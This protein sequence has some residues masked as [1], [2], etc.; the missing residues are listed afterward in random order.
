MNNVGGSFFDDPHRFPPPPLRVRGPPGRDY[1]YPKP[2][3]GVVGHAVQEY[4]V[5]VFPEQDGFPGHHCVLAARTLVSVMKKE[6]A[7]NSD[8]IG[9]LLPV[10]EAE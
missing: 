2:L 10:T 3:D 7:H 6:D 1:L 5:S 4:L 8:S 9:Y